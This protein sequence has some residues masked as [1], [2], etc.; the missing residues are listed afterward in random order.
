MEGTTKPVLLPLIRAKSLPITLFKNDQVLATWAYKTALIMDLNL[1]GHTPG[2]YLPIPGN[3][4]RRFHRSR[5]PPET[6]VRVMNVYLIT[7]T[8]HHVAFQVCGPISGYAGIRHRNTPPNILQIFPRLSDEA[9]WPN[10]G[11]S[12]LYWDDLDGFATRKS[13]IPL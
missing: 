8:I 11:K 4:F 12:L 7:F 13:F 5:T 10:D 6:G 1:Q 3:A 2:R 9:R